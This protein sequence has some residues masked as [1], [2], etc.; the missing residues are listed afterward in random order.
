MTADLKTLFDP[1]LSPN[2]EHDQ[3]VAQKEVNSLKDT[4]IIKIINH[5]KLAQQRT[6]VIPN[7][8]LNRNIMLVVFRKST[9]QGVL[10]KVLHNG[11]VSTIKRHSH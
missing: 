5:S 6:L 2:A 7:E 8:H 3:N 9:N 1:M 10:S 4:G 11:P